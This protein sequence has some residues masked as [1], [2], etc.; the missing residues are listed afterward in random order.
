MTYDDKKVLSKALKD[1]H[2]KETDLLCICDMAKKQNV[3]SILGKVNA[4]VD[5]ECYQGMAKEIRE[6]EAKRSASEEEAG[7]QEE[8]K[9]LNSETA[10]TPPASSQ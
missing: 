7:K 8:E 2:C 9:A 3:Q 4:G 10:N 5:C 6:E 1:R